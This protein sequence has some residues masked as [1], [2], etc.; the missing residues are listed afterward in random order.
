MGQCVIW[1][2][3]T[4]WVLFCDVIPELIYIRWKTAPRIFYESLAV[5]STWSMSVATQMESNGMFKHAHSIHPTP[6]FKSRHHHL[7]VHHHRFAIPGIFH[8]LW[9]NFDSFDPICIDRHTTIN[10]PHFHWPFWAAECLAS[11]SGSASHW[12]RCVGDAE[13]RARSQRCCI[14]RKSKMGK[15]GERTSR[16]LLYPN[17]RSSMGMYGLCL[18]L[19]DSA[20]GSL[21]ERMG[22]CYSK[23]VSF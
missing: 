11:A 6:F 4:I 2:D 1:C 18:Y 9:C 8:L 15:P 20:R 21:W 5:D 14:N 3:P 23:Y 17:S 19:Y 22:P 10:N 13:N 7:A 16:V 12:R